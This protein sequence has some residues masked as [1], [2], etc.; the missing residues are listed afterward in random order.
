MQAAKR[1]REIQPPPITEVKSW[2]AERTFPLDQPLIDLCQAVPSYPPPLELIEHLKTAFNDPQTFKYTPD[3]GLP[4]VRETVCQWYQ[5]Y[6]QCC[7][8]ADQICLT[9]GASQAFW[10]AMT[11]LCKPD[12]EV[13]VQLPAYF[14]H[15]MGLKSLGI[16]PVYAPFN[17]EA[18]GQPDPSVIEKLITPKTK[19]ILLVTPSN[20][21]GAVISPAQIDVFYELAK[22]HNITL[23]LDETYNSFIGS[24]PH[25][26]FKRADWRENFIH[27]ASFGKTFALTGLRCGALIADDEFIQQALKIQDSLVVCQPHPTQLALAYGCSNLD[28]W[29]A[30]NTTTMRQRHDRFKADFLAAKTNFEL[31]SSGS[32]FAW[33]KHPWHGLTGRQAAKRLV[34]EKNLI[35]LPGETFGPSLETYLRLSFGNIAD[36][37]IREAVQRFQF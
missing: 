19:A 29:V 5:R 35:C 20:P 32:F 7:P 34:D 36:N 1:I 33:V 37:Q 27:I 30:K 31:I 3:E 11:T 9:I 6:Y 14:D 24:S 4:E 2:L 26:L 16:K 12:D 15:P 17:P 21:T 10:L 23:I 22:A 8:T 25:H 18:H 28:N 13:I